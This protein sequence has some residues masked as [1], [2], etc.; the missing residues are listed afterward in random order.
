MAYGAGQPLV[1]EDILVDPP[2]SKEVRIRIL[3]TSICHTDLCAWQGEVYIYIYIAYGY[4]L[5]I[6]CSIY[7]MKLDFVLK[8]EAQRV[9]PR[10]FGHEA[11]G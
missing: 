10:I 9:Y 7:R 3:F 8:N 1:L 2:R 4:I 6:L 5:L 11:S